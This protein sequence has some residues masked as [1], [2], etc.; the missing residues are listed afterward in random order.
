MPDKLHSHTCPRCRW[1]YLCACSTPNGHGHC[2]ECA[3]PAP[4]LPQDGR[5][6]PPEAPRAA[7]DETYP[8]W[9]KVSDTRP[10]RSLR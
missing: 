6:T 3:A 10:Y 4:P 8:G 7:P 2:F 9:V 1:K 5:S